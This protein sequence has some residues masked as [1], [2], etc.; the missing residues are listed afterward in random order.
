MKEKKKQKEKSIL[1]W[2]F[3]SRVLIGCILVLGIVLSSHFLS[4]G[5]ESTMYKN[6]YV[7]DNNIT[8]QCA[9]AYIVEGG[10]WL[11]GCEINNEYFCQTVIELK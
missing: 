9:S 5:L 2:P 6:T 3:V 1:G 4:E 11:K 7:C 10:V 8:D